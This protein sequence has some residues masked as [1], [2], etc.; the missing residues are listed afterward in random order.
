MSLHVLIMAGGTGGHVFPA[1][2]VAEELKSR[3]VEVSWIGTERGI[4]STLVPKAGLPI[5]YIK[6]AGLRGNGLLGWLLAPFKLIKAVYQSAQL[7]NTIKPNV[8]L[9]LGGFASGPG[10][11][12][13]KLLGKPLAIHEQNA[14]PGMTNQLLSRLANKVME[15]FTASFK[16]SRNALW[17]GNPVRKAIEELAEPEQRLSERSGPLRL[18]VLGGSL[19]A[20]ALNNVVPQAVKLLKQDVEVKHQCG[21]RHIDECLQAYKKEGV[22]ADVVSFIDDMAD[23][24]GWADLVI[25]R[26]GALTVAELSAAGVASILVPFPYAVDDHQTKNGQVLTKCG[27]AKL[28]QEKEL[29]AELLAEEINKLSVNRTE[30]MAMAKAARA[31]ANR[32]TAA[33]ISDICM[34]LANA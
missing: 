15:A 1:L 29:S 13:A 17:V 12:A 2:A 18:L 4:E 20:R 25:C 14:I 19:G 5:H 23:V 8:V 24:Y 6:V 22:E 32:N 16:P 31:Q 11:V 27:A 30:L 26:S 10:G 9:G 3:G 7:I 33:Q 21:K 28:F 34:E